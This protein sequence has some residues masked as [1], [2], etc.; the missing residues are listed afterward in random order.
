MV[1]V[2]VT[3]N[4]KVQL[5][6]N[7]HSGLMPMCERTVV[8]GTCSSMQRE[9]TEPAT[10]YFSLKAR[11][12]DWKQLITSILDTVYMT[13]GSTVYLPAMLYTGRN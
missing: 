5:L 12:E 2:S 4:S 6:E 10:S 3:N 1:L 8:T 13:K 11:H 9:T 7:T